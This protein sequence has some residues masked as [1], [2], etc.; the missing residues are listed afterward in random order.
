MWK[1]LPRNSLFH[2]EWL[3]LE[4]GSLQP[5]STCPSERC[6]QPTVQLPLWFWSLFPSLCSFNMARHM[7]LVGR[8]FPKRQME[9]TAIPTRTLIAPP[10]RGIHQS[11]VTKSCSYVQISFLSSLVRAP[12]FSSSERALQLILLDEDAFVWSMPHGSGFRTMSALGTLYGIC[13]YWNGQGLW[14]SMLF[15]GRAG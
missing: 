12:M 8:S 4:G 15:Y 2:S 10:H 5:L 14:S 1:A 3:S 6:Q 13:R 7:N 9:I 11:V